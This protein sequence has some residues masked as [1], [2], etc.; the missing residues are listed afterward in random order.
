MATKKNKRELP[1]RTRPV[2][3][4]LPVYE[5]PA[6][7]PPAGEDTELGGA[8]LPSQF[9]GADDLRELLQRADQDR[10]GREAAEGEVVRLTAEV[11][12][13]TNR[14]KA[15]KP[16]RFDDKKVEASA[17]ALGLAVLMDV[18]G[19]LMVLALDSPEASRALLRIQKLEQELSPSVTAATMVIQRAKTLADLRARGLEVTSEDYRDLLDHAGRLL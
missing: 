7:L 3:P 9:V 1:R 10:G 19:A 15:Q 17:Q 16:V 12:T 14:L 11:E 2:L 13:L 4:R 5:P 18:K 8:P 6:P